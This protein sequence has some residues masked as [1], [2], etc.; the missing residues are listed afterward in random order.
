MK[1]Y[2]SQLPRYDA[3]VEQSRLLGQAIRYVGHRIA[4]IKAAEQSGDHI[5]A[6]IM[7]HYADFQRG[8]YRPK[9]I[10]G[11]VRLVGLWEAQ[12]S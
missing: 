9:Q 7:A 1:P 2:V 10:A 11:F 12:Q 4:A 3:T 6:A 8:D 5:A